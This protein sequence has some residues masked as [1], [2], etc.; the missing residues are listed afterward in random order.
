MAILTI[1]T[2]GMDASDTRTKQSGRNGNRRRA[3]RYLI[4]F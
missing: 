4:Q 3:A 2:P 1:P